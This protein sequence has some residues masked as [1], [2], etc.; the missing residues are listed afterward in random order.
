MDLSETPQQ[1]GAFAALVWV[2]ALDFLPRLGGALFLLVA[3][4]FAASWASRGMR[5]MLQRAR[6][7]DPTLKPVITAIIR[8]GI[9]LL[10]IIAA[11]GQLGVQTASILAALGAIVLAIGLAL[12][13]TL[14]NLAAGIMLL[15]LR[16]FHVSDFIESSGGVA[17]TVE[18]LG[19]FTTQ[20]RTW[21]GIYRSVPNAQLWNAALTNHSRNP[22][23]LCF[24]DFPIAYH[25][26]VAEGR[27]I[28]AEVAA[29]HPNVLADPAP[30]AVPLSLG[31]NTVVL[32]L[33]A[34]T[35]N[36][37]LWD[38][39]WDLTQ[40]GKK[41]LEEAGITVSAPRQL[42]LAPQDGS[43]SPPAPP[44]APPAGHGRA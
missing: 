8:Y 38:T 35:P 21:D 25:D 20:L 10:V 14:A 31:E 15:W 41:R 42:L 5:R 29:E 34:W 19:F 3:G 39:R 26:D 9:L 24:I 12:Q 37:V 17:G 13:G 4:A 16:P 32:Q 43:V 23:R 27:R 1:L 36:R 7:I 28:L 22:T 33:R 6:H 30:V 44:P 2:W 11:L 18:E 40:T